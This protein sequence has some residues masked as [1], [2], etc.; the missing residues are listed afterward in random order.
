[1]PRDLGSLG[2]VVGV[3]ALQASPLQRNAV[4]ASLIE[5]LTAGLAVFE[6]EGLRPFRKQWENADALRDRAVNVSTVQGTTHGVAR[7]IDGDGALP[8]ETA[9]GVIRFVSGEVSVRAES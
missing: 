8:V 2:L 6:R 4:L 1:M 3:C 9:G 7:G 5:C